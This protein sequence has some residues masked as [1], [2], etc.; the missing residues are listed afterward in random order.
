[1]AEAEALVEAEHPIAIVVN[2]L[3]TDADEAWFRPL[4]QL[5]TQSSVPIVR[6]SIPSP[7][8]LAGTSEF[9]GCLIKPV[10][11]DSLSQSILGEHD[12]HSILVVDD[13]IGFVSLMRRMLRTLDFGGAVYA[14][15]DGVTALRVAREQR[16]DLV[17]LD[18]VMPGKT[19]F[20]VAAAIRQVPELENARVVAVTASSYATEA[21]SHYGGRFALYRSGGIPTGKVADLLHAVLGVIQ[22]DY[23]STWNT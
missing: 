15:Y 17:L 1:M 22:P 21:L 3:P 4:G 19:G 2:C 14:A 23:S 18:L 9:D 8:W 13:D 20:E 11:R 10:S 12:Y 7:S 16:P 5:S 6:C